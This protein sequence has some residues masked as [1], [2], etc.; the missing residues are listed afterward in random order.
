MKP[1]EKIYVFE[2]EPAS[3]IKRALI[4]ER[5]REMSL[6]IHKAIKRKNRRTIRTALRRVVNGEDQRRLY[7]TNST[8]TRDGITPLRKP[9]SSIN[10]TA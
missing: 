8:F 7:S 2:H 9:S 1:G 10:C 6:F 3:E 5:D 4:E